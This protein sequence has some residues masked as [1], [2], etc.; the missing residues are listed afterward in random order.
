MQLSKIRSCWAV[1]HS[2]RLDLASK[3]SLQ[4]L[5]VL[6][7]ERFHWFG[8]TR[9]SKGLVKPARCK[10]GTYQ[11]HNGVSGDGERRLDQRDREGETW[12]QS[13]FCEWKKRVASSRTF[14]SVA[15]SYY[16]N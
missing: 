4:V 5:D 6:S 2:H 13:E 1:S 12:R 9:L 8:S 16:L 3:K 15:R 10:T 11:G 7:L 14:F